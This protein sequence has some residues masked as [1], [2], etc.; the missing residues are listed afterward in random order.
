MRGGGGGREGGREEEEERGNNQRNVRER[1]S[2]S[3]V[4][5]VLSPPGFYPCP[6]GHTHTELEVPSHVTV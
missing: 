4:S 3:A 1:L 5:L 6:R 2:P